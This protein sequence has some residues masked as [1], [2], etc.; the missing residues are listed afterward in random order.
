MNLD[1]VVFEEDVTGDNIPEFLISIDT[2]DQT[3]IFIF[4]CHGGQ[5]IVMHRII[6][7][8]ATTDNVYYGRLER[9]MDIN[10]DGIKE[11]IYSSVVIVG[12]GRSA[13]VD[14]SAQVLEWDGNSFRELLMDDPDPG[15]E[16]NRYS[17]NTYVEVKDIDGNGTKELIFP[18]M[19]FWDPS[20]MGV[21]M[22]CE[23]GVSRNFSSIW[24][25]DGE[26]YRFMWSE[27]V[28]PLYRFQAAYDG[29]YFTSIGLYDRAER[30]YLNAINSQ[31]LKPGSTVD[32]E[33][34]H[35]CPVNPGE[36]PDPTE[37]QTITAYARLRLLELYMY[38]WPD[39]GCRSSLEGLGDRFPRRKT[40]KSICNS[41]KCFLE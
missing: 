4:G 36:K 39:E 8:N 30:N 40:G 24:M 3:A 41:S 28:S 35:Q 12:N 37:R 38:L 26:Y 18:A 16:W 1:P 6:Y 25:W 27:P 33:R 9:V 23:A 15:S 11:I 13:N 7:D 19:E 34:D 22:D 10:A 14:L 32:W 2:N 31:T 21:E 20:G 17:V 5:Y 29:D